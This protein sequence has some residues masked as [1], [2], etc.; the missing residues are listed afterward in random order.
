[1]T[2]FHWVRLREEAERVEEGAAEAH[3]QD[4]PG[5][6]LVDEG[7]D[8]DGGEDSETDDPHR[9]AL[10]EAERQSCTQERKG[11]D[12]DAEWRTPAGR[13]GAL[14]SVFPVPCDV[15]PVIEETAA[16][17]KAKGRKQGPNEIGGVGQMP[18]RIE[19]IAQPPGEDRPEKRVAEHRGHVCHPPHG[20][21][22]DKALSDGG[23]H[24]LLSPP[25]H[26]G[27]RGLHR[28]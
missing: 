9:Q 18:E 7:V 21:E 23:H 22:V 5:A 27:D 1:M 10:Q 8:R 20:E 11:E 16:E 15:V 17:V 26:E 28:A 25:E 6:A 4:S 19:G 13:D 2:V 12:P 14:R 24:Q 3:R